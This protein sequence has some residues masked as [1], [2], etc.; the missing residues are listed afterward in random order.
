MARI[1]Y[2]Y[3]A[4]SAYAYLGHQRLLELCAAYDCRLVHCPFLL[5]PVME[6]A[7]GVPFVLR[8]KAHDA[9]FFGREVE[10]WSQMRNAPIMDG[11]PTHHDNSYEL[12]NCLLIATQDQGLN[13]DKLSLAMLTAHWL[14]D[15]DLSDADQLSKLAESEGLDG[16][17]LLAAAQRTALRSQHQANTD[18]AIMRSVFGSPTY[19]LDGEMFYGQDRLEMMELRLAG[20]LGA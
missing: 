5:S 8:S 12:A 3:S 10:R 15:A 1:E 16:A 18:E 17:A 6:A 11:R 14:H 9:Y 2:F 19:F 13:V 4:H 20:K 7:G